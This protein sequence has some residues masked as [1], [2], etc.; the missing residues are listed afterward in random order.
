V[1]AFLYGGAAEAQEARAVRVTGDEP[2]VDGRLDDPAWDLAE[3]IRDLVQQNPDEGAIPTESTT[4]RFLYSDR[5]LFVAVRAFDSEPERIRGALTRRDAY[6]AADGITL[7][8]DSYF[9]RRTAYEFTFNP[10]GARRDVF[11]YDDGAG[12]DDSW[13]PVYDWSTRVDSL[14]WTLEMRIPF[15]QLRFPTRDSLAFGI[16]IRR[17]INRR[18]EEANWPFFPR[19]QA[20]E[21]S[22]YGVLA[23]MN[24]VPAP[25]RLELLPYTAGAASV[26][27]ANPANPFEAS[28]RSGSVRGGVDVKLG[29]T[30]GLTLDLTVNPDFGQVEADAAEVNLTAFES[31]FPEKR[32]FFVEGTNLF[33]FGFEPTEAFEFGGFRRGGQEGLVYTRRVGRRPQARPE[34]DGYAEDVQQTTIL[35][36][37]KLSGQLGNGWSIGLLQA[38]TSKEVAAT[39]DAGGVMDE[40]SVEPLTSYSVARIERSLSRGR[41][42]YGATGTAVARRL[43]ATAFDFLHDRAF[44]AGSDLSVRFGGDDYQFDVAAF[45]SR[46]EG[47]EEALTRTQRSAARYFQ[48]PD[49]DYTTL[50]S[51]RTALMG[52]GGYAQV[53]KAQGFVTWKL[54][55]TTRSPG[56]ESNDLGFMRQAD[57]HEQ[58]AEVE[59]RWLRPGPVFR[60]FEWTIQEQASFTYGWERTR[61][62]VEST[63]SGTFRNYWNVRLA[64]DQR[65]GTRE[66]RLLRGGPSFRSPGE[67]AVRLSARTDYRRPLSFSTSASRTTEYKSGVERWRT[68]GTVRFRPGRLAVSADVRGNWG[69]EDRQYVTAATVGDSTY[70]VLGRVM[71]REVAITLRAEFAVTPRLSFEFYAEPFVSAGRYEALRL[72][73]NPLA[74]SYADRFSPLGSDRLSRAAGG[75]DFAVDVD[76]DGGDDFTFGDPNF[77][78]VSL[79]TNAVMRW[80]FLPGSTLFVVWQQNREDRSEDGDI[81]VMSALPDTFRATGANVFAVK[82]SYWLGL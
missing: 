79:R 57:Q 2:V 48:R 32:P 13:D 24:G 31:F 65:F 58:L 12:R 8:V 61:T 72:A 45:G 5:D 69:R 60:Q 21:V 36:A 7:Y 80:E 25:R 82:I 33:Q 15:S 16:R 27:P 17:S 47:S 35:G 77:S 38:V 20:G 44:S 54:R 64:V 62:A 49:N 53:R 78:V 4:V 3:P 10:S 34:T 56:F 28:G 39:V 23:G 42:S 63:V 14:G 70:Y 75:A 59:F 43:D 76:R 66:V 9:D 46:V 51:S 50:D 55:Y 37:A 1:S 22:Q 81:W 52:F 68:S 6:A 74:P 40:A 29:V 26:Q 67:L 73:A 18:N 41:L 11:I 30:S 71:R 19:D